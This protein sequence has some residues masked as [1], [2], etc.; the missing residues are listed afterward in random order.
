MNKPKNFKLLF[1]FPNIAM[2]NPPPMSLS[3]FNALLRDLPVEIRL[4]DTTAYFGLGKKFFDKMKEDLLQVK[5]FDFQERNIKIKETD[6]INDLQNLVEEY[7]PDLIALSCNEVTFK[8]GIELLNSIKDFKSK[9]NVKVIVGGILVTSAPEFVL[10]YDIIDM[11]CIGEG[12]HV[13]TELIDRMIN[14]Q[15]IDNIKNIYIKSDGKII[16]NS[17]R[18]LVDLNELPIPDFSI[19]EENRFYRPMGGKVWR[20]FPIETDRGCPYKCTYCGSPMLNK[21]YLNRFYRKKSMEKIDMELHNLVYNWDAEYIFFPSDN[22]LIASDDEFNNFIRIYKKYQKPFWIQSRAETCNLERLK[23]LRDV[24]CDRM[25]LGLEHGNEEFRKN[26]LQ[27][28]FTNEQF[29]KAVEA[30]NEAGIILT[31]NNMIGFP[32][33]T[34]ELAFDT[35]KFNRRIKSDSINAFTFA[36]FR[37]TKL[38]DICIEKG[39]LSRDILAGVF[40][41]TSVLNMPFFTKEEIMG[42]IKTFVLYVKMPEKYWPLIKEAEKNDPRGKE[43]LEELK[44]EYKRLF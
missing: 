33:E 6:P 7:K 34:R 27:K 29:L 24:G 5:P 41:E 37:G 10:S 38:Y 31:V 18:E 3:I 28:T 39:Y 14:G 40:Q 30:V 13:I 35:I 19:F 16:K 22:F 32:D 4:F 2:A 43:C 17:I 44:K 11:V 8:Q 1:I 23:K 20:L 42:L 15:A 25:S 9:N 12:E 26:V 21:I 36:P